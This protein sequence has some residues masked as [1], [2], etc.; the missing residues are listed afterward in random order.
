M[1]YPKKINL[2]KNLGQTYGMHR[3]GWNYAMGSLVELHNDEGTLLESFIE[4]KFVWGQEPGERQNKPKPIEKPWVGFVHCPPNIPNWFTNRESAPQH[5]FNT[6]LWKKSFPYCKGLFCLSNYLKE[7][8][9]K[10]LDVPIVSLLHPTED[11]KIKFTMENFLCN[12]DRG[13]VRVGWWLRKL[14][15]IYL[16]KLK[17]LEKYVLNPCKGTYDLERKER[18]MLNLEIDEIY[19]RLVRLLPNRV[20]LKIGKYKTRK[21]D[22]LSNKYY[23]FFLS[24]NIVLMDLWDSSANNT[25]IECITR[26]TPVLTCHLPAVEEYLGKDYPFYFNSLQEASRKSED[27]G[28]IEET[29]I[30]LKSHPI[31]KKLTSEYFSKSFAESEIYENL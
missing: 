24:K 4:K 12:K 8:L 22:F 10:K 29:H 26:N 17:N 31:K 25:I 2:K 7:Y 21:I 1:N 14:N 23:D 15:S 30:Y 13:I 20:N 16:L 28:L 9:Q 5:I 18:A 27:I 19:Y 6:E 11:P 3:S